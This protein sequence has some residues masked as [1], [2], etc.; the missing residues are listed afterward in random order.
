MLFR[1]IRKHHGSAGE[2]HH[3]LDTA[4]G[5]D[6]HPEH[7]AYGIAHMLW[8]GS[9]HDDLIHIQGKGTYSLHPKVAAETGIDYIGDHIDHTR[10]DRA[11][12]L[13]HRVKTHSSEKPGKPATRSL[14]AQL[15][16]DHNALSP[17]NINLEHHGLNSD[18][19]VE[20]EHRTDD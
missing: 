3:D 11:L 19:H 20:D 9:N 14:T 13:R 7:T 18:V 12:N 17:S 1:S 6:D 10:V 16:F 4:L 15:T 2:L 8:H 5:G